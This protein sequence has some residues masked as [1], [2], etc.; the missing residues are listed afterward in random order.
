MPPG[1]TTPTF[2]NAIPVADAFLLL[3]YSAG[4]VVV[5]I[6]SGAVAL[7]G[8]ASAQR[9]ELFLALSAGVVL[10]V[11]GL[12][13]LPEA[14]EAGP[15]VAIALVAG[16]VFML[17]VERF[18]LP[19]AMHSPH[20]GDHHEHCDP[21][22]ERE[23]A[24]ADA[25]GIGAFIG[26]AMHT[27]SDGIALGAAVGEGDAGLMVFIAII[28]HKIPSAFA[29]G[30]ILVRGGFSTL[31]VVS[32][33]GAL[34]LAVGAGALLFVV[35]SSLGGLEPATVT[36]WALAFSAGSFLHVA[37]TD[38]LPDLHR[39]RSWRLFLALLAGLVPVVLLSLLGA[40]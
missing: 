26:L 30:S 5:A 1:S 28:A 21:E 38:L 31:V 29:L 8:R 39:Q 3:L 25:S 35:T 12:H 6:A 17:A 27:L 10:G 34:G 20:A 15:R 32:A 23:H 4:V 24:R 2:R 7:L 13:M 36:P 33:S 11:V 40:H 16:F 22:L 19:H 37:V 14:L 9:L 18:I